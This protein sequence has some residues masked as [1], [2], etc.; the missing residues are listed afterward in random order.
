LGHVEIG[1]DENAFALKLVT[2]DQ[3]TQS[4][5]MHGC[6]ANIKKMER[7]LFYRTAL[8]R[9]TVLIKQSS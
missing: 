8:L 4:I 2:G 3:V 1:S 7:P 6:R 9:N 5:E